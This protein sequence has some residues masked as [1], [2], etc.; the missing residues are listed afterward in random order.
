MYKELRKYPKDALIK[1]D[2]QLPKLYV[3]T[4]SEKE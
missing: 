3:Y 4:T 1:D 2:P